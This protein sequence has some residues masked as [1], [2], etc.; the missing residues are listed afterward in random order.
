MNGGNYRA[1]LDVVHANFDLHPDETDNLY[2]WRMCLESR[3]GDIAAALAT[4][5]MGLD[6][7]LWWSRELLDDDDLTMAKTSPPWAELEE[8]SLARA[9]AAQHQPRPLRLEPAGPPR[10]SVVVLHTLLR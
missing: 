10:G 5:Q 6:R 8:A 3:C 9:A 7:G 2:F 1:A 4:F